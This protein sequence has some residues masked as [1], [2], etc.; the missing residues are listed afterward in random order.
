M[1]P[2]IHKSYFYRG[3][4][5]CIDAV[6]RFANRYALL[7]E[8]LSKEAGEQRAQ[9]LREMA[10]ILRRVPSSPRKRCMR[11]S[12]ACGLCIAYCKSRATAIR[13]L[14]AEWI[15]YMNP[16]YEK[17]LAAGRITRER[18]VELLVNLWLKTLSINKIRPW[19]HTRLRRQPPLPEAYRRRAD[20]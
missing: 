8:E 7:A 1:L 2:N 15:E 20:G 9:E 6:E 4:I 14:M 12:R 5:I 10:E 3:V 11:P 19:S 16:F 17:D 13:F 18:G